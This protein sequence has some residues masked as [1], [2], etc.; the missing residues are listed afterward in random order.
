MTV[1]E[2]I[3]LAAQPNKL[4]LFK[5]GIFYKAYNQNA[6]WFVQHIKP[7]KVTIKYIKNCKQEVYSIGFPSTLLS[8]INFKS[9]A[10]PNKNT[11]TQI[12]SYK[13]EKHFINTVAYINWCASFPKK[14]MQTPVINTVQTSIIIALQ[15]F[16]ITI[17]TPI[18]AF[19]FLVQLKKMMK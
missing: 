19:E 8:K 18:Q 11:T 2:K 1:Q 4:Y 17:K 14:K 3:N 5:E 13:I 16:N 15:N 7:Y 10:L 9:F 6:M 12:V